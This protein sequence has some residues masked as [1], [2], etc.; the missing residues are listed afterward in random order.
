MDEE[1]EEEGG[2]ATA[3]VLAVGAGR[4]AV[5]AVGSGQ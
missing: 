5:E 1:T 3:D 2:A 4:L